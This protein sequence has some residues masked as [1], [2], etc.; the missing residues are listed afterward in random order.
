[1]P[2]M[3]GYE[4]TRILRSGKEYTALEG[5]SASDS[6]GTKGK[7]KDK[8]GKD[9]MASLQNLPVIAMTASAIQ[10]DKEKC[11]AAGLDDYLPKP[12]EKNKME[13][14]LV[15]WVRKLDT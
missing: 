15:K 12:V 5:S 4:A 14:M 11:Q 3:D 8:L 7:G 9:D 13:E 10:G 2:V 1:M 6:L